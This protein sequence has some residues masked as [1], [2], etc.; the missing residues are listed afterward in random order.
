MKCVEQHADKI[1]REYI[2][3][4]GVTGAQLAGG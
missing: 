1:I 3:A 4:L 2:V